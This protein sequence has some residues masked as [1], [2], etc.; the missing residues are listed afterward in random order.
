MRAVYFD[1][2]C[3]ASGDMILAALIDAGA[4]LAKL[5]NDL[6]RLPVHVHV[7]AERV[8][9]NGL[10]CMH[11][12]MGEEHAHGADQKA[13]SRKAKA[14]AHG[15]AHKSGAT[16]HHEQRNLA[17][18]LRIIREA[19]FGERVYGR[20]EKVLRRIGEAEAA[21]HGIP[22]E[23]VHF[24]E[25][26][27][28][29]TI[30]DVAGAALC[31]EYLGLEQVYF[32]PLTD[33][34]GTV[35]CAHGVLPVPVPAVS[36]MAQGF[37]LR[38]LDV[39]TELLTPTGCAIL[40]AL[41]RQVA[42]MPAGTIGAVGSGCGDKV[43]ENR[44]N[45]LRAFMLDV[46]AG[47]PAGADSVCVLE[48][49][50]DHVS[51]E[52]MSFAA[53]ECMAAGALDVSWSP[54]FMKKGRPGYRLTVLCSDDLRER[55]ADLVILNTRTLGVRYHTAARTIAE[56]ASAEVRLLGATV[57]EKRCSYKGHAFRKLEYEALAALARASNRPLPD[58]LD[59]YLRP[60]R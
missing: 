43:L 32:G 17:E 31:L 36:R 45:A 24:H 30:I 22:V 38:Q 23:K 2:V 3:G 54:V 56:R 52:V 11:M 18:L 46:V 50:M 12:L 33:G 48:S 4:P 13:A 7:D 16:G 53:E 14:H 1:L 5:Q 42:L 26:G 8:T 55:L 44:A 27:A 60:R 35:T 58:V 37:V 28:V 9:R 6:G 40:T 39:P 20:C 47:A 49:D 57:T 51:G 34:C 41:G 19:E 21:V 29:D 15:H 10:V 59:D 25:V